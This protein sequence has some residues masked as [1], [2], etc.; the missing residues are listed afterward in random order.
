MFLA[1][2]PSEAF[3]KDDK[4]SGGQERKTLICE[5]TQKTICSLILCEK[6]TVNDH[7]DKEVCFEGVEKGKLVKECTRRRRE[8]GE[9]IGAPIGTQ[10]VINLNNKLTKI[11]RPDENPKDCKDPNEAVNFSNY[12]VVVYK[13]EIIFS[14]W[15]YDFGGEKVPSDVL[16]KGPSIQYDGRC[17]AAD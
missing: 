15:V 12:R 6:L 3:P 16:Y 4:K 13:G 10:Y 1:A 9:D 8:G 7:G 11:C 2:T 17:R 14:S 5:V